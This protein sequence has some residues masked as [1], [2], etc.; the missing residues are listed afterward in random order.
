MHPLRAFRRY[1]LAGFRRLE[2]GFDSAFG[3]G[4]NPLRHLGALGFMLF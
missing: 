3:S 1:A 2:R 4:L